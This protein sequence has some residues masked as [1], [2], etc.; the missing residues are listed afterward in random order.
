MFNHPVLLAIVIA[1]AFVIAAWLHIQIRNRK[2]EKARKIQELL[3]STDELTQIGNKKHID[4]ML[5]MELERAR[6]HQRGL[7]FVIIEIDEFDQIRNEYGQQFSKR[8]LRET[9]ENLQEKIR[10]YDVLA[11]DKHRFLCLFP[12][13]GVESALLLAKRARAV[14]AAEAY[15]F[16]VGGDPIHVTASIGITCSRPHE[17]NGM[18]IG[19]IK[20]TAERAL[21][22]AHR[23][24][25]NK[26]EYIA[27]GG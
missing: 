6:R 22:A 19:M 3:D 7:S 2:R 12:E 15:Y 24:G 21:A 20:E 17:T 11:R 23:Q 16:R 8:I 9:A 1:I 13:T 4:E 26:M 25:L 27:T 18:N 10:A 5:E 14:V